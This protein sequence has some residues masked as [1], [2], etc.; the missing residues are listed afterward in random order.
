MFGRR[1]Q[2]DFE[3][4]I[5]SHLQ[6][7]VDRLERQGMSPRDAMRAARRNFGNVGV[8]EDRFYHAQR[9]G[10]VENAA[11]DLRHAWRSLRRTPGFL[12]AAVGTLS[13]AIGAVAGMFTVVNAV[14]LEPLPF[15]RSDRLVSLR[16]RWTRR[17]M[18]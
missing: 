14:M 18:S 2:R 15:P 4:E 13:L 12:V 17:R 11:R 6:L 1:S 9:L 5:R 3:D 10:W 8:A 7:E 16:G